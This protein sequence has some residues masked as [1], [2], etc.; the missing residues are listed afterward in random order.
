MKKPISLTML[1]LVCNWLFFTT[2][3]AQEEG[4]PTR[5]VTVN[6]GHA[7]GGSYDA[8]ARR[9]ANDVGVL[10]GQPM[11]VVARPGAGGVVMAQGIGRAKPDGYQIGFSTSLNVTLDAQAGVVPFDT[12]TVEPLVSVARVQSVLVASAKHPFNDMAGLIAYTKQKG[13]A[14]FA[15][16]ALVDELV[17]RSIMKAEGV[18]FDFIPYKGGS[19]IRLALTQGQIDFGYLGGGYKG[20]VDAG[21][22]KLLATTDAHRLPAFPKVPTLKELGYPISEVSV[23]LFIVPAGTPQPIKDKLAAA[24]VKVASTPAF[25][26]FL[27]DA[28]FMVPD[29]KT[30]PELKT[31]LKAQEDQWARLLGASASTSPKPK[32]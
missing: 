18:Q 21:T 24:I 16:Q 15:K 14:Q 12:R 32:N 10:L 28:L 3:W 31:M 17:M 29:I 30:G 9:I 2:S 22:I 11:V 13:F 23:G 7:A 26:A 20:D 5:A 8:M 4:W 19:E 27:T 6:V 25:K 1:L